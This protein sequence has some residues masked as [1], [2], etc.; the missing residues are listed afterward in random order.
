MASRFNE[1]QTENSAVFTRY[2]L[3]IRLI[4]FK[5]WSFLK[6]KDLKW[7]KEKKNVFVRRFRKDFFFC[8][9]KRLGAYQVLSVKRL[10]S[11]DT[12]E[13][14]IIWL[15]SLLDWNVLME[16][17]FVVISVV[18]RKHFR[19]FVL[20]FYYCHGIYLKNYTCCS[21]FTYWFVGRPGRLNWKT[22][23]EIRLYGCYTN[24]N[25]REDSSSTID[26]VF[27]NYSFIFHLC[28]SHLLIL[29]KGGGYVRPDIF[30][31]SDLYPIMYLFF[32]LTSYSRI[33]L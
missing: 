1:I 30:H 19:L 2:R 33:H 23:F 12:L 18:F 9:N 28:A 17:C 8:L 20:L 21:N 16:V 3:S 22:C 31:V 25:D 10:G 13:R 7:R 14:S 26:I 29:S 27:P 15:I 4:L 6:N 24:L 32:C 5:R 11:R